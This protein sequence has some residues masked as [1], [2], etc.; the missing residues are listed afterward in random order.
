MAKVL[1]IMDHT[2][3]TT[4]K[5]NDK[6]KAVKMCLSRFDANAQKSFLDSLDKFIVPE[7]VAPAPAAAAPTAE[8]STKCP[9]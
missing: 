5:I 2:G 9:F 6:T 7:A 4:L 3:H 1:K 8:D